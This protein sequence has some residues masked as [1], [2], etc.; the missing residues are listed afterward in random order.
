MSE[1]QTTTTKP[2]PDISNI[3]ICLFLITATITYGWAPNCNTEHKDCDHAHE[4]DAP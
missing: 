2:S 4:S 3:A 1:E